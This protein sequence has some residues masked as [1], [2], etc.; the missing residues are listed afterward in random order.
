MTKIL[1]KLDFP[2]RREMLC[3]SF[4]MEVTEQFLYQIIQDFYQFWDQIKA[5]A[6]QLKLV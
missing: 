3:Q 5:L 1:L 4:S 6:N 2:E